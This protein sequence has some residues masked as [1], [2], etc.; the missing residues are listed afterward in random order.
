M[1]KIDIFTKKWIS[2]W[3]TIDPWADEKPFLPPWGRAGVL[4]EYIAYAYYAVWGSGSARFTVVSPSAPPAWDASAVGRTFAVEIGADWIDEGFFVGAGLYVYIGA[5][6]AAHALYEAEVL[7]VSS[8]TAT[9]RLLSLVSSGGVNPFLTELQYAYFVQILPPGGAATVVR[10]GEENA[11]ISTLNPN[12]LYEPHPNRAADAHG[13]LS[14]T[15]QVLAPQGALAS[16]PPVPVRAAAFEVHQFWAVQTNA[17]LNATA[18]QPLY[19]N[20]LHLLFSPREGYLISFPLR[21]TQINLRTDGGPTGGSV[22]LSGTNGAWVINTT[23]PTGA[24]ATYE[25]LALHNDTAA[26]TG[27]SWSSQN[28]LQTTSNTAYTFAFIP[29]NPRVIAVMV[30][31]FG[32]GVYGVRVSNAV[33]LLQPPTPGFTVLIQLNETPNFPHF[34]TTNDGSPNLLPWDVITLLANHTKEKPIYTRLRWWAVQREYIAGQLYREILLDEREYPDSAQRL[35]HF[36]SPSPPVGRFL[37]NTAAGWLFTSTPPVKSAYLRLHNR[38]HTQNPDTL[39]GTVE[40]RAAVLAET[41]DGQ[42]LY[43]EDIRTLTYNDFTTQGGWTAGAGWVEWEYAPFVV[44][45]NGLLWRWRAAIFRDEA[46]VFPVVQA[47]SENPH[48]DIT[49]LTNPGSYDPITG[50]FVGGSDLIIIRFTTANLPPGRYVLLVRAAAKLNASDTIPPG[51]DLCEYYTLTIPEPLPEAPAGESACP[52][53]VP[54]LSSETFP[55][56]F[57]EPPTRGGDPIFSTPAG[58]WYAATA[59]AG[60]Y[61]TWHCGFVQATTIPPEWVDVTLH[62]DNRVY[63]RTVQGTCKLRLQGALRRLD[64]EYTSERYITR[65]YDEEDIWRGYR[66]RYELMLFISAPCMLWQ[67]ELIK[68]ARRVD[69]F[70]RSGLIRT[71]EGLIAEDFSVQDLHSAAVV[72]IKLREQVYRKEYRY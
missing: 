21:T 36:R 19:P 16:P 13:V 11:F 26:H 49:I 72:T 54:L 48:P 33:S 55:L 57:P 46:S 68:F 7:S 67:A 12:P 56:L 42:T 25:Y 15:A 6:T 69:V 43:A 45:P 1:K 63:G 34:A 23:P 32:G 14:H 29:P 41:A 40:T 50:A 17:N 47:D 71:V 58:E 22:A 30:V 52:P 31:D 65:G 61:D 38:R 64:D 10:D 62:F 60:C 44:F 28:L 24:V 51:A 2:D 53:C 4:L 37:H 70:T 9:I 59:E 3:E 8:N 35:C 20:R 66:A 27:G 18:L 39:L 5:A